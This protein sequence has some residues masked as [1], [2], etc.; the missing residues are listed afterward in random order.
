MENSENDYRAGIPALP[1]VLSV[2][3]E[4]VQDLQRFQARRV[5]M[6]AFSF[7]SGLIIMTVLALMFIA[8]NT[9]EVLVILGIA[10]AIGIADVFVLRVI[11]KNIMRGENI[12]ASDGSTVVVVDQYGIKI[13][14]AVLPRDRITCIFAKEI[15]TPHHSPNGAPAADIEVLIG[16]D[17]ISTLRF[18]DAKI[19]L[20]SGSGNE[21]GCYRFTFNHY[22]D[23][24][25]LP[26]FLR[27]AEQVSAR[28]FPVHRATQP[29]QWAQALRAP[30]KNRVEIWNAAESLGAAQ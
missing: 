15:E 26:K 27:A 19:T 17:Q 24:K 2:N 18:V 14:E 6:L 28:A 5:A 29:V 30:G 9:T 13:G 23:R 22:L 16:L 7:G 3:R 8:S 21:A 4:R 20:S 11:K 1:L 10:V 12:L 25:D